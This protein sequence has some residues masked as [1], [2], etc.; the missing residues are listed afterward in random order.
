MKSMTRILCLVAIAIFALPQQADAQF[1]KKLKEAATNVVKEAVTGEKN[2]TNTETT[3]QSPTSAVNFVVGASG[4]GVGNPAAK[5]FDVEFV[6][7]VGNSA[8]NTVTI[9]LKATSK[10]LNY[11]NVRIGDNTVTGYDVNGNEYKS[12]NYAEAKNMLAGLPVKFEISSLSK[13]PATVTMLPV[14]YVGYYLNGDVRS[15]GGNITT[16]IQLK[17]VPVTWQ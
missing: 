17:N 12:N 4:V 7:A 1:F 11:S 10:D 2:T 6:E 14:V 5:H 16:G 15:L 9:T 13:V 3:A 8:N